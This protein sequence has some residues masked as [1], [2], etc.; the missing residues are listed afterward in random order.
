MPDPENESFLISMHHT[1]NKDGLPFEIERWVQL[2]HAGSSSDML[3]DPAVD[4]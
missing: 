2:T 3:T 1:R 4:R